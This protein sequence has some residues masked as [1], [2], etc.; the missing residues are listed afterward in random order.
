MI[1]EVFWAL[2]CGT[3]VGQGCGAAC[4]I[5]R[6]TYDFR[7]A[8]GLF[9]SDLLD[10]LGVTCVPQITATADLLYWK[11]CRATRYS[12]DQRII[13]YWGA[14]FMQDL[15]TAGALYNVNTKIL[16]ILAGRGLID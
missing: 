16:Q 2:N 7:D 10:G 9:L 11:N 12:G 4:S 8:L 3:G 6:C 5:D 15:K 13:R 1:T 14:M